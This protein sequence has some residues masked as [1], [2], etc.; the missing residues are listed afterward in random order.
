MQWAG[1]VSYTLASVSLVGFGYPFINYAFDVPLVPIY[2]F[3]DFKYY[4]K[5]HVRM[6]IIFFFVTPRVST[7]FSRFYVSFE[8]RWLSCRYYPQFID[9]V[10]TIYYQKGPSL[11]NQVVVEFQINMFLMQDHCT[12]IFD[13][14]MISE[15]QHL[16]V[17]YNIIFLTS[18]FFFT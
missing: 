9:V 4:S 15:K 17:I 14:Y 3:F 18:S 2:A 7:S 6:P 16:C 10:F 13:M 5:M 1:L 12:Q 11:Y 8:K